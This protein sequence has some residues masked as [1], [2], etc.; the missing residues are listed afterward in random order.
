MSNE[1]MT[2]PQMREVS[3]SIAQSGFYSVKNDNQVFT[4]MLISQAE[5]IHPVKAMSMYD[6]IQGRP[7]LKA[8]EILSRFQQSS[9]KVEWIETNEDR[10][11]GKFSH[12][13]GGTITVK[14]DLDRAKKSGFGDKDNYKK[15]PAQMYR[16]RCISEAVRAIFPSCLNSMYSTEE[17]LD[18]PSNEIAEDIETV[19]IEDKPNYKELLTIKL[20]K[21]GFTNAMVKEFAEANKLAS[22]EVLLA[23]LTNNEE[24]LLEYVN[25]FEGKN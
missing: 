22:D 8:T 6:I 5:G 7:A 1:L 25:E 15:F 10:A 11:I 17:V 12:P 13:Q 24:M 16:S 21:I 20:R 19:T 4:L 14:W 2:L 9:G 18:M 23:E 3:K